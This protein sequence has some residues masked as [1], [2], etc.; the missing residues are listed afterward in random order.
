MA[1]HRPTPVRKNEK[2]SHGIPNSIKLESMA[3]KNRLFSAAAR[4]LVAGMLQGKVEVGSQDIRLETVTERGGAILISERVSLHPE[5][6]KM[7][8]ETSCVSMLKALARKTLQ[9]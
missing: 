3:E 4:H 5:F 1:R 8:A 7:W 6:Q 9:R 2:R